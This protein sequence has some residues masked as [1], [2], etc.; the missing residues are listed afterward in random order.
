M[1]L[2][3]APDASS[4]AKPTSSVV[5]A[6]QTK[7]G[8]AGRFDF[9][10]DFFRLQQSGERSS[11]W[12]QMRREYSC[13]RSTFSLSAGAPGSKG[14]W[15]HGKAP[16]SVHFHSLH[17]PAAHAGSSG[18]AATAASNLGRIEVKRARTLNRIQQTGGERVGVRRAVGT[19]RQLKVAAAKNVGSN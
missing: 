8:L 11:T 7:T 4:S 2:T 3:T 14:M 18:A 19:G 15:S 9:E 17:R 1:L 10:K 5:A 13:R 12:R 16:C 6:W